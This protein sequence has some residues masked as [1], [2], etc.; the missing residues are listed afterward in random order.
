MAL[1]QHFFSCLT[2]TQAIANSGGHR[3]QLFEQYICQR[4]VVCGKS[5]R[6]SFLLW[7]SLCLA[8]SSSYHA[9][10]PTPATQQ[11]YLPRPR[12]NLAAPITLTSSPPHSVVQF[13]FRP[14]TSQTQTRLLSHLTIQTRPDTSRQIPIPVVDSARQ[15]FLPPLR[16]LLS[17]KHLAAQIIKARNSET[18]LHLH[19][20]QTRLPVVTPESEALTSRRKPPLHR[21]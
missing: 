9:D 8:F 15:P 18:R 17:A 13:T 1:Y 16:H 5:D 10:P 21:L 20:C 3:Q 7:F 11:R 2:L 12:G 6:H 19:T 14:H 4:S